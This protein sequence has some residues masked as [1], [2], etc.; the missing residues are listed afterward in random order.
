MDRFDSLRIFAAVAEGQ[1]FAAA[2]R[3]LKLSPPAVTRAVAA[4][5]ARVGTRLLHRTTRIV[6]PTEAGQGLL[7]DARRILNDLEEAEALAA[8][9]A[10][11]P[12][13]LLTVTAPSLF[14]RMFVAPIVLDFLRAQPGVQ[15][16]LLLLDRML[17]LIEEGVDIAVRIAPLPDSSLSAIRVGS[18]RRVICAAPAYLKARGVPRVPAEIEGHDAIAFSGGTGTE[19]WP[20]HQG[21]RMVMVRIRPRLTASSAEVVVAAAVNGHGLIRVMSYQS[22]EAVREKKLRILLA[23]HEPPP[24]PIH[25]VHLEGRRANAKVR[26]FLDFA[27]PRLRAAGTAW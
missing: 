26:A 25:L 27:A 21:S 12:R 15:V 10:V 9:A 13:G 6:R 20:L 23:G 11:A 8:G 22:A 17:D 5:E 14:G 16:R 18:M 7:A 3:R 24:L 19:E 1:S 2:A 4:L